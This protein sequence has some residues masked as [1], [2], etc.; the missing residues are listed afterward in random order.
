MEAVILVGIQASGKST[1]YRERFA[2]THARINLDAL[3]TRA[4]EQAMLR[5]CIERGAP[6]VVDNT[7]PTA[8]DRAR[9]VAPAKAAG[10]RVV[11][12][13][14]RAD[15]RECIRRNRERAAA[16]GRDVPIPGVWGTHKRLEEPT[17]DEGFD[18]IHEVTIDP[19]GGFVVRPIGT[20]AE[21][22]NP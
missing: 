10:Y 3:K 2:A 11:A 16:G 15:P 1:F 5:E 13:F 4:R 6:F 20:N 12:F 18:A 9:Y 8:A 21:S 14:F 19:A 17:L 7:N 22:S